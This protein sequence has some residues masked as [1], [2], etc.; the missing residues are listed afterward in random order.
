MEEREEQVM[1][2]VQI[3]GQTDFDFVVK[4]GSDVVMKDVGRRRR[5][6]HAMTRGRHVVETGTGTTCYMRDEGL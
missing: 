6:E 1:L 3:G 2:V 5:D 4:L